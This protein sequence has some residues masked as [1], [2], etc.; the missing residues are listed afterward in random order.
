[1][2]DLPPPPPPPGGSFPPPPAA[3]PPGSPPPGY[4]TV[5]GGTAAAVGGPTAEYAGFGARFGA[6]LLDGVIV[7]LFFVPAVVALIAGPTRISTCSVDEQGNIT[8][9]QEIN[10][11]CE[12]PTGGTIATALLLGL[13]ALIGM[14]LYYTRMIG[15]S[16]QTLG[17]RATGVR[18]VDATSGGPIGG[19][20]A[21][22]R[23]LFAVFFS[24]N[25]F[26]LGYLW[27]LWDKRNQ[28]WHDKVV[29]SVV[30]KA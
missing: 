10:S 20:R 27:A 11:I 16:G 21:L 13:A 12:V 8:I 4:S 5:Y 23:Y 6:L 22:G 26:A 25:F 15:R 30:V 29:S 28:T 3:P 19:G 7:V 2:S 18:V 9:G 14:V 17:K 24:G 1:M